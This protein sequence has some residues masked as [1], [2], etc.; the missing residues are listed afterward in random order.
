MGYALVT[1]DTGCTLRV[2]CK[3]GATGAVVNL[4][5]A[6]VKAQW[7]TLAGTLVSKT[8]TITG[9]STGIAEYRFLA[10]EVIAPS[11]SIEVEVTDSSGLITSSL[12]T[13]E[14]RVRSQIG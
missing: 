9:A 14:F 6:T 13:I 5:G 10:G 11:M 7:R 12:E 3:D 8:M 4:A 1:G 2:T